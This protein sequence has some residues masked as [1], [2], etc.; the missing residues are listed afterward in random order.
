MPEGIADDICAWLCQGQFLRD[1]CRQPGTPR[2]RTVYNWAAKDPE[3]CEQFRRARDIG[4]D[5]IR[6][7]YAEHLLGPGAL[8]ALAGGKKSRREFNRRFIRPI[9]LR[10][11]RWRKH[12]R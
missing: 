10:L 9:D 12:P 4:E 11:Q 1:Y 6:E 7:E 3:F 2:T 8:A 5:A